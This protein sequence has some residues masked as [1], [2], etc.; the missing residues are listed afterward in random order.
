MVFCTRSSADSRSRHRKREKARRSGSNATMSSLIIE[1][2][3]PATKV[4]SS[5]V[6][7]LCGQSPGATQ[8]KSAQALRG[9]HTSIATLSGHLAKRAIQHR[10]ERQM[11][12]DRVEGNWKQLTGKVKEQ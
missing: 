8:R 4:K 9:N 10:E 11:N 7:S 12:W 6:R 5:I 2:R 3:S 1:R